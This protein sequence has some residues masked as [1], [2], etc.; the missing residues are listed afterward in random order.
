MN[1]DK[2][3][4]K[5][6]TSIEYKACYGANYGDGGYM[7]GTLV[8]ARKGIVKD[9]FVLMLWDGPHDS[10]TN[11]LG[12]VLLTPVSLTG[13]SAGT[14]HT[15]RKATW[16][17]QFW[18]K[19]PHRKKGYATL[20]MKEVKKYDERPHVFPHSEAS[21]EFFSGYNITATKDERTW[22]RHGKPKVA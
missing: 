5:D 13:F 19:R 21:G 7:R 6:L 8:E 4:V 10:V 15:K 3:S 17:V 20:L 1:I 16:T 2:K 9:A 18:I 12:W 11:M 14:R 22:L